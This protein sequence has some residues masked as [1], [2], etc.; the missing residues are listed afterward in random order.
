MIFA[1]GEGSMFRRLQELRKL[2]YYPPSELAAHQAKRLDRLLKRAGTSPY[3]RDVLGEYADPRKPTS[4]DPYQQ[5]RSL[6]L[7]TK[8]AIQE[9]SKA[10]Q[11]S[12]LPRR[13]TRK[14]TGGS[15]GQAVTV[16]KDRQATARER[17][18]MWLGYSWTGIA[19]GDRGARFW[20]LPLNRR[21]RGLTRLADLAMNRIRFSAFAFNEAALEEYWKTCLH[22]KPRYFHGYVSMLEEFAR[23]VANT[24]KHGT[25]LDLQGIVA[26][27]EVLGEPQRELIESTFGCRVQVEYGCGE[28]GPIAYECERGSLHMLCTELVV[29]LLRDDNTPA[30]PGETA[31][32]V[33]TDLNNSA[34]ALLRYEIGDYG[35]LGS[36]CGCGRGF[37]VL[38]NVLGRAYDAIVTPDGRKYHGEFFMYVFE[39]LRRQGGQFTQFQVIQEDESSLVVRIVADRSLRE[40]LESELRLQ[41]KS[42]LPQ[43]AITFE[44]VDRIP[45]LASGKAQ[46]IANNWLRNIAGGA[47]GQAT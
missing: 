17:A 10:L 24:G 43:M 15:T 22:F 9:N 36:M 29:E 21:A 25:R 46:V 33:L 28:M 45:R 37:P 16:L 12:P 38:K 13:I 20:G 1:L 42:H 40:R 2:Q 35:E 7:L 30:E 6:P 8:L 5:L 32:I 11:V 31:R 23:F 27:S 19:I 18:A 14:I 47:G 39:E 34:M 4:R 3:Y 26:T 44:W 41:L